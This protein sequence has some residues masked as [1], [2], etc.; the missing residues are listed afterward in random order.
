VRLPPVRAP[1]MFS[2]TVLPA[3]IM[4]HRLDGSLQVSVQLSGVNIR[5]WEVKSG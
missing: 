5:A 2:G 1:A 4:S 3:S